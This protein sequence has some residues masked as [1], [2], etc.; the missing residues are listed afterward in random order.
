LFY[1]PGSVEPAGFL[2]WDEPTQ[3]TVRILVTVITCFLSVIEVQQIVFLKMNYWSDIWNYANVS[4]IFVNQYILLEHS[5]KFNGFYVPHMV[6]LTSIA[7]L[8]L[9]LMLFYWMRLFPKLAFYVKMLTETIWDLRHFMIF[10]IM[11]IS[12][13]SCAQYIIDTYNENFLIEM[14]VQY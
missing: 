4:S 6:R 1:V 8:M 3:T 10:F 2:D 13:F 11:I 14:D 7:C 9:S 5:T 12:T